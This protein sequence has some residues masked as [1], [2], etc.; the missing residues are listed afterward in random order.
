[1]RIVIGIHCARPCAGNRQNDTGTEWTAY[2]KPEADC[3]RVVDVVGTSE[4]D[5]ESF[6]CL[7]CRPF[8]QLK[9]PKGMKRK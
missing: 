7:E 8:K 6:A 9:P 3:A 5:G 4:G 2:F 1:M